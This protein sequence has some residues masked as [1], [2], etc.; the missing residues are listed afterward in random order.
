MGASHTIDWGFQWP[1]GNLN[2]ALSAVWTCGSCN[3]PYTQ[4]KMPP[5]CQR[6][7]GPVQEPP[8]HEVG[9]W[10]HADMHTIYIQYSCM[11]HNMLISKAS[12]T[13]IQTCLTSPF[14]KPRFPF[15]LTQWLA[16]ATRCSLTCFA[17]ECGLCYLQA[18]DMLQLSSFLHQICFLV[19]VLLPLRMLGGAA[20]A[21]AAA[22]YMAIASIGGLGS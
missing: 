17:L 22:F 9:L 11:V 8:L 19:G 4:D 18:A 5:Q 20:S 12:H 10:Q 13:I 14:H 6:L 21:A 16:P 15:Y 1:Q 3:A 7:L 2:V